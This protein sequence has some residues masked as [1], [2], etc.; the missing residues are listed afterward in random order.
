MAHDLFIEYVFVLV[1]ILQYAAD[2]TSLW[3]RIQAAVFH[4]RLWLTPY[5]TELVQ[6]LSLFLIAIS[7]PHID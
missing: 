5:N 1:S 4:T 6:Q 2:K 7:Y 3:G